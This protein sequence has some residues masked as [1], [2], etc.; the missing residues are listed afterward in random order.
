[1]T[2]IANV[3]AIVRKEWR[4]YFGSPIAWVALVVWTVLFGF[5]FYVAFEYFLRFS[6]R[7]AQMDFGGG[8][9]MSLNEWLIRPVFQNMA[10]VTLFLV[11][12][13]TMRL[14]A[15]EKRQ[16]TIELLST[17]PLTD[18]QI[19]AGK[20]LAALGVYVVMLA[21]GLLD[22]ALLWRYSTTPPEWKP[23]AAGVLALLL[24]ASA[25]IAL[26]TFLS[27]LTRNQIVAGVLTFCLLLMLWIASWMNDPSAGP[28]KQF[29]AELG[30]TT[31]MDDLVA[32]VI[33]TKDVVF[34]LSVTFVGLFLTQ[35]SLESQR[36]RA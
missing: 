28:V 13:L 32:G 22:I 5:F 26:G 15:E 8:P 23:V 30:L 17:L 36:W 12:M 9:K 20:F 31:H 29:V 18:V 10:V 4:H 11:P 33:E 6:M 27:T 24:L 19:V 1:M 7:G 34:Y 35:R 3:A 14:F 25:A 2:A 16:G 21:A